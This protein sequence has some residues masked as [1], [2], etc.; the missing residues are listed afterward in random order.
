M[1][2][3]KQLEKDTSM[4]ID[5][6]DIDY[7]KANEADAAQTNEAKQDDFLQATFAKFGV[8]LLENDG[9]AQEAN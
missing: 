8:D 5:L 3:E 1:P 4:M 2:E 7:N 9:D 6:F